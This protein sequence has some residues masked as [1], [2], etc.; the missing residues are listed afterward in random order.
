MSMIVREFP[1][2]QAI[3]SNKLE[4][5]SSIF[6][7]YLRSRSVWSQCHMFFLKHHTIICAGALAESVTLCLCLV[8]P[9]ISLGFL[10]SIIVIWLFSN[11]KTALYM[12]NV[13]E[14]QVPKLKFL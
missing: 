11:S 10:Q 6:C 1:Y 8:S 7:I 9:K 4:K 2:I 3:Q 5:G 12:Y 13:F 14:Y